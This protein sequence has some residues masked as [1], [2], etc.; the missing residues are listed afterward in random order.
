MLKDL[1]LKNRTYRR[2]HGDYRLDVSVLRELVDLARLSSSGGNLQPLKYLLSTEAEQNEK[3]FATLGWA[4]YLKD[5]DGPDEGE[6]PS[7][8]IVVL[9]DHNIGKT[10]LWDHGIAAQSILLGAAERGLGGCM[11]GNVRRDELR[12]SLDLDERYEILLVIA[13]GRPKEQVELVPLGPDGDV[14]YYRDAA[15]VHYVPKRPLDE[16]ILP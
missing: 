16:L 4:G 7:G 2:F 3:I 12:H 15:G 6:R 11:F 13:I 10:P 8:Y 5:W 14:K 1:V 9:L